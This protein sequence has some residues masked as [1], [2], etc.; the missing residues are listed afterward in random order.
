MVSH[1]TSFTG[2]LWSPFLDYHNRCVST[3]RWIVRWL[4]LPLA[5]FQ[6]SKT[7]ETCMNR[8]LS[9]SMLVPLRSIE[10]E[11]IGWYYFLN[12]KGCNMMSFMMPKVRIPG[13][14]V[15]TLFI[16]VFLLW[17]YH[18]IFRWFSHRLHH[19]FYYWIIPFYQLIE[20]TLGSYQLPIHWLYHWSI[21]SWTI[22][23]PTLDIH[24]YTNC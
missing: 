3:H 21:P 24:W 7:W 5:L 14:T 13:N 4:V 1:G 11:H 20:Y 17:I 16:F 22:N 19:S 2:V 6:P 10:I 8:W 23:H 18:K 12:Q 15:D 9:P